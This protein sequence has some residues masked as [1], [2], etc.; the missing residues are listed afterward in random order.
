M[1]FSASNSYVIVDKHIDQLI[2]L[3]ISCSEKS[4]FINVVTE[5]IGV[6]RKQS[7]IFY[8]EIN[9]FFSTNSFEEK[10]T[11]PIVPFDISLRASSTP[12]T[13]CSIMSKASDVRESRPKLKLKMRLKSTSSGKSIEP[14]P[15]EKQESSTA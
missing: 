5:A 8:D 15:I 13:S 9:Q 3:F 2:N 4:S 1:W 14:V 11:S 10:K 12:I 6:S 7:E